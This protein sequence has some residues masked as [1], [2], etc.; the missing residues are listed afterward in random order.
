MIQAL[1][2]VKP[3]HQQTFAEVKK[4]ILQTLKQQ[5]KSAA[6]TAFQQKVTKDYDCKVDYGNGYAPPGAV[7]C[8]NGKPT[9]TVPQLPT[10]TAPVQT[11]PAQTVPQTTTGSK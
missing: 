5:Q 7:I 11:A 3:A 6:W 4:Q 2:P 8:K 1:T 9:S 10:Q